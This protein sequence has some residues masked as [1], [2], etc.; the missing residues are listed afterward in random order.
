MPTI[1][2]L[3]PCYNEELD[4]RRA[5]VQAFQAALPGADVYVYDNN[6]TRRDAARSRAAPAR[7]CGRERR[8]GKG[9]V[10]APDV[11]GHRSRHLRHGR[12]R[13][14]LRRA[15]APQL[16]EQLLA[17]N[18]DMVVGSRVETDT[19]APTGR[20]TASA[21]RAHRPRRL[22]V[23]QP[24][25]SDMLSGYRVFSRRFVKSFPAFSRGFEIETELTV[26]ALHM[27]MPVAEDATRPTSARPQ[28]SMSKLAHL[29]RRHAHP[30]DDHRPDQGGAAAAVLQLIAARCFF[31]LSVVLAVP[32]FIEY[33]RT[34]AW[35]RG[36]PTAILVA[37]A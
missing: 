16:V 27:A 28:G 31:L 33:F 5:T 18:L 37:I 11:R 14:H 21:T 24:S 1:A 22:A 8:Q 3:V 7:S 26:H 15:V 4:R 23:R 30:A 19:G 2:V 10:V 12:R 17:E 35:C 13:R 32:I 25:S 36:F 6:S 20:A 34:P 29:P 9:N